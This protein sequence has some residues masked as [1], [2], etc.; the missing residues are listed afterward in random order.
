MILQL[1]PGFQAFSIRNNDSNEEYGCS[2]AFLYR[3][4]D[5]NFKKEIANNT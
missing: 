3:K 1:L 2:F 5:T 4:E